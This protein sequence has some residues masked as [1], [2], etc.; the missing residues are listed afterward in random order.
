MYLSI[1]SSRGLT[2]EQAERVES[3][4]QEFLPKLKAEPGVLEI[5]HG[6]TADGRDTATVIVWESQEA[7]Q[8][9]R[10]GSLIHEPMA[11]EKELGLASVREGYSVAQH[12]G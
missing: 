7:A 5:F 9:Y 2:D 1:T 8:L 11:L 10:E 4:L 3:F 12:L 6:T